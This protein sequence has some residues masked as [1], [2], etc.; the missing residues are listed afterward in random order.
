MIVLSASNL[1]NDKSEDC[2]MGN[3]LVDEANDQIEQYTLLVKSFG[4]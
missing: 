2:K 4:F 3:Y 1:V